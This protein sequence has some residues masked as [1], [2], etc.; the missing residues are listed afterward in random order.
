[1]TVAFYLNPGVGRASW[2]E[3]VQL[4]AVGHTDSGPQFGFQGVPELGKCKDALGGCWGG[5]VGSTCGNEVTLNT[6]VQ[7]KEV[8]K[9]FSYFKTSY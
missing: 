5:R 7:H 8:L 4:W 1:M 9:S 2:S 3:R 6:H